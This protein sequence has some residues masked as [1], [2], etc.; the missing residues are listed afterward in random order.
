MAILRVFSST[1]RE[2]I[3]INWS[4]ETLWVYLFFRI[5]RMIRRMSHEG[6]FLG[7]LVQGLVMPVPRALI[8]YMV[9]FGMPMM[10]VISQRGILPVAPKPNTLPQLV[11]DHS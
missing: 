6:N 3:F 1:S 11:E 4:K 10:L 9:D 2:N 7:R 8:S 5:Y